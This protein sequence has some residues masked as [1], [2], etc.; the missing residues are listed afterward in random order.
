M[1]ARLLLPLVLIILLTAYYLDRVY[2]RNGKQWCRVMG[3]GIAVV[4]M[5]ATIAQS[6]TRDYFPNN[7]NALFWY[8]HLLC[9]VVVPASLFTLCLFLGRR[10]KRQR[11][12]V[13]VGVVLAV[14]F[15]GVY[16]YGT[17]IGSQRFETVSF[18]YV[19]H[20]VPAAFN[21]YKIVQFGDAHVGSYTGQRKD[22]LRDAVNHINEQHADLV[23]FTGDL[24]NKG[25]EEID[26][27][28][29]LLSSIRAKDGVIAVLGNHDYAEYIGGSKAEKEARSALTR[30]AIRKLGW[31]LL[32]NEHLVIH[33]GN[34]S[35][36]IAGMENDG[37]GRFP[38]L[39]NIAK[40]LEGVSNDAF[41]I[42]LE[43]DPTS[44]R[45]KILP[46]SHAQLTLSGHTHGGQLSVLGLSP[47]GLKYKEYAGRYDQNQR[48]LYV[49]KGMGGVIPFRL[50][51]P[52]EI[53]TIT[54]SN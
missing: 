31:T 29:Q 47:A 24:Q 3:W 54:I 46:F 21:G 16:L 38:C 13:V 6:L 32:C 27:H 33:R 34:D 15:A 49:T 40:T 36:V 25:A 39:G 1:I 12:G 35:I 50:G 22:L 53:V 52:R 41:V 51:A 4:A 26:A 11:R 10:L 7:I 20:A 44:W 17:F 48:T 18:R 14:L 2:W 45:R 42:M 8:L 5:Y 28:R 30:E 43:H 19:H 37:E 9:V 23:V